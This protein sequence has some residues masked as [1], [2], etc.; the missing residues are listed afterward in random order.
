M[1]NTTATPNQ[2]TQTLAD[3]ERK[4]VTGNLAMVQRNRMIVEMF[5]SGHRQSDIM[6]T[7][8][9]VRVD[10]GQKPVTLGAVHILIRRAK[11]SVA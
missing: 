4:V 2:D 10:M 11:E 1:T 6:R 7:I 9:S 3:L 5:D 8:N